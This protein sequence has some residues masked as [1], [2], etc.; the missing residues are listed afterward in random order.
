MKFKKGK[1]LS[2]CKVLDKEIVV[3]VIDIV[4]S[5]IKEIRCI[6]LGE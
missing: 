1:Y 6:L 2:K 4:I 3:F 5:I